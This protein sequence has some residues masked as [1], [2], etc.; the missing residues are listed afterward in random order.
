VTLHS[1]VVLVALAA[2]PFSAARAQDN[3]NA[4]VAATTDYVLRGISQTYGGAAGQLGLS[5]QTAQGWFAGVWGSN[6]DPYPAGASSAE[7]DLYAGLSQPLR[8]D[9][10]LRATFTRYS[11][12]HDP[13][14]ERYDYS[15]LAATLSYLDRVALTVSYLPDST[16]YSNLGFAHDKA[17]TGFEV[18]AGWPAWRRLELVTSAGY[19]DLHRLFGVGYWAGKAGLAYA[20]QHVT[21]ELDRFVGDRT[22]TRLYGDASADGT[23]A[24]SAAVRF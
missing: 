10:A 22:L 21:V 12:L 14:P 20:D 24:L 11:Y 2:L 13:R 7:V 16:S 9:L 15:E 4:T 19:Y 23:W 5:Y 8:D 6:V 17:A 1:L 3:W 18:A